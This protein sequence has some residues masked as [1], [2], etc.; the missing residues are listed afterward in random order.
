M[1]RPDTM[2]AR[3]LISLPQDLLGSSTAAAPAESAANVYPL[4][5]PAQN[6]GPVHRAQG[7]I[8]RVW[9]ERWLER[10]WFARALPWLADEVPEDYGLTREQ[11]RWLCRRRFWRA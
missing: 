8:V 6:A 7:W 9:W 3:G 5:K 4:A 1:R 2:R 11:A 10:R